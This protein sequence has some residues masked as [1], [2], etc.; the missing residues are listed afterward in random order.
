MSELN[1]EGLA[2]EFDLENI[3]NQPSSVSIFKEEGEDPDSII[4]D[5]IDR[6][7]RI[8]DQV[9]DELANGNFSARLVEV[10]AK[11]MDSVT[12]AVSQIQSTVY[13]NDYLQL[14]NRMVELKESEL[15]YKVQNL[16]KPNIGSQNIIL[17]DR[18]SVLKALKNNNMDKLKEENKHE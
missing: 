18:E 4:K 5:N 7:N 10:A 12:N 8:L 3:E 17:T 11:T 16:K 2:E 14:K 13:N 9:E 6:A 15:D 1:R